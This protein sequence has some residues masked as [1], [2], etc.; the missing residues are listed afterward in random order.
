MFSTQLACFSWHFSPSLY[1]TSHGTVDARDSSISSLQ[2][3]LRTEQARTKELEKQVPSLESQISAL[4]DELKSTQHT[5]EEK[6]SSLAQARKHLRN[7]RER[8]MVGEY[9][10]CDG[11]CVSLLVWTHTTSTYMCGVLT[12]RCVSRT[13]N[14]NIFF[15]VQQTTF[16]RTTEQQT[17]FNFE[18]TNYF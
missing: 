3:Q 18:S 1:Q 2:H 5:L 12:S 10:E 15:S 4:Q 8:N 14:P 7:A 11:T 16:C 17:T 13:T 6:T 9:T